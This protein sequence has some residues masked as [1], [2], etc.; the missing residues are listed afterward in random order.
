[1]RHALARRP[2][3][4]TPFQKRERGA[5]A[6]EAGGVGRR[7]WPRRMRGRGQGRL[8]R[9]RH[10]HV[11][12]LRGARARALLALLR[13]QC[14][15]A[16]VRGD[17]VED[18]V[19]EA[20]AP[21]P[22]ADE[23]AASCS[24]EASRAVARVMAREVG[25]LAASFGF[26]IAPACPASPAR[27]VF[28]VLEESKKRVK[29]NA[30]AC[31]VCGKSFRAEEYLDAHLVRR[32]PEL[33]RPLGPRAG[34]EGDEGA[35]CLASHCDALTCAGWEPI[36]GTGGVVANAHWDLYCDEHAVEDLRGE[37]RDLLA[38]CLVDGGGERGE[39]G[40]T[41]ATRQAGLIAAM[42]DAF[43]GGVV[44]SPVER[45]GMLQRRRVALRRTRGGFAAWLRRWVLLPLAMLLAFLYRAA[46]ARTAVPLLRE[47]G[48]SSAALAARIAA[49]APG[50]LHALLRP[51]G[52]AQRPRRP[53]MPPR[54]TAPRRAAV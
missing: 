42:E 27:S 29:V 47:A 26:E 14:L 4:P 30:W 48:A 52:R 37:C 31:N 5:A 11:D 8:R 15:A 46:I 12:P 35:V 36:P 38:A 9:R 43:C 7:P 33:V 23:V 17:G 3:L 51:T 39:A 50:P 13:L 22:S 32:H 16:G 40:G 2:D 41:A 28:A 34:D 21:L 6:W 54:G 18:G 25:P 19:A 1:M 44:C 49:R 20:L 10:S 24:Q 53:G 45:Q